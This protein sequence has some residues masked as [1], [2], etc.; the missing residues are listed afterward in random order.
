MRKGITNVYGTLWFADDAASSALMSKFIQNLVLQSDHPDA[1]A[2]FSSAQR[3]LVTKAKAGEKVIP[4]TEMPYHPFF[5][6]VGAIF[7]K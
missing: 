5:W 1:V 4:D 2:A 3:E 7:G 6:A